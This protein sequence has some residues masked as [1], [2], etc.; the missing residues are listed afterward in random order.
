MVRRSECPA[1]VQLMSHQQPVP[2]LRAQQT[3]YF[4]AP[5]LFQAYF[6]VLFSAHYSCQPSRN[7]CCIMT[8]LGNHA[9]QCIFMQRHCSTSAIP[10]FIAAVLVR[11]E[12]QLSSHPFIADRRTTCLKAESCGKVWDQR[13]I[14]VEACLRF[15]L[16]LPRGSHLG[17]AQ[18]KLLSPT[19]RGM[20]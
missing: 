19:N 20:K 6:S 2:G 15:C 16:S 18:L 14:S 17:V 3:T 1:E 4:I 13:N 12:D 9:S 7:K 11:R 10:S 5:L 8:P